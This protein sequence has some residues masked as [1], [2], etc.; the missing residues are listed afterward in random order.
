LA[1]LCVTPV[2]PLLDAA[3]ARGLQVPSRV[4]RPLDVVLP[5]AAA[6]AVAVTGVSLS[7]R[8]V[9]TL[10]FRDLAKLPGE[11]EKRGWTYAHVYRSLK[12]PEDAIILE[13]LEMLAPT[14]PTG[15]AGDDATNAYVL[16]VKTRTLPSPWPKDWIALT[17]SRERTVLLVLAESALDW[18]RFSIC[19]ASSA[20]GP[21]MPSS[22]VLPDN[23]KP[24]CTYCVAGMPSVI[25]REARKL[26]LRVPLRATPAGATSMIVMPRW[27]KVCGGRIL[28]IEGRSATLSSDGLRATWIGAPDDAP[29]GEAR[30][31]WR[32]ESYECAAP[33]Y[34]GFPPFFL[35]GDSETV[36]RLEALG[37]ASVENE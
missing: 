23:K 34:S 3:R 32:L 25:A 22:L 9:A 11:L 27:D 31:E 24:Q 7:D 4:A 17:Q 21:C 8:S 36:K 16:D 33:R 6:V 1:L 37:Q 15:P 28:G 30:F 35:E 12:A 29:V 20:G 5:F 14:Y 2:L 10:T 19:G 13:S 26:E 18:T